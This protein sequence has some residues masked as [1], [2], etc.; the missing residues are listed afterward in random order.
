MSEE[1]G[2]ATVFGRDLVAQL[3]QFVHRPYLVVTI[4]SVLDA[5]ADDCG[6]LGLLEP[7]AD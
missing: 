6:A 5:L 2:F 7:R 4:A 3:P 1:A